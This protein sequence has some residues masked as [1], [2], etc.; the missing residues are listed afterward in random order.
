MR[1]ESKCVPLWM[2]AALVLGVWV[3]ALAVVALAWGVTR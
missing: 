3:A 1:D 2:T